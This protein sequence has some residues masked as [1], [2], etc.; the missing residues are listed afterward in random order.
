MCWN[1]QPSYESIPTCGLHMK[2]VTNCIVGTFS[3]NPTWTVC[4]ISIIKCIFPHKLQSDTIPLW[5]KYEIL[6]TS[7]IDS[8][9]P[10]S[11]SMAPSLLSLGSAISGSVFPL[12]LIMEKQKHSV[13]ILRI[14]RQVLYSSKCRP[15]PLFCSSHLTQPRFESALYSSWLLYN[16]VICYMLRISELI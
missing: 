7:Q 6:H 1:P 11:T 2:Q 4:N 13:I 5:T 12:S 3:R 8:V 16:T 10:P 9:T 14:S 15:G